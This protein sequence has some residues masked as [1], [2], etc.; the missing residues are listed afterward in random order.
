MSRDIVKQKYQLPA[1]HHT[2]PKDLDHVDL[3]IGDLEKLDKWQF[4]GM[5]SRRRAEFCKPRSAG[6]HFI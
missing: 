1:G 2:C 6:R 4:V 3:R 5:A